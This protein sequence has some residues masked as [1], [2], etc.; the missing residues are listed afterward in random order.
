MFFS[1][2]TGGDNV[3]LIQIETKR[4]SG[5]ANVQDVDSEFLELAKSSGACILDH[6]VITLDKLDVAYLIS[7]GKRNQIKDTIANLQAELVIVSFQLT[8]TQ[9]RN[10]ERLWQCRVIDR[11]GLI[12]DIFAQRA[13]TF[14]GKLQ[15]ELAQLEHL[16]TRLVRGWTHLE[17]QKGGIGLRGPGE[18]QLETDKRL[19]QVRINSL[20][21]R[22][23]KVKK[24]RQNN[25]NRRQKQSIP[26]VA[27][28]GYTNAG[29]S[30]LFNSL[31]QAEVYAADQLFATL[32]TTMR[33]LDLGSGLEV[34]LADT[35]GFIKDLPH[36]LVE[37]FS[38]TLEEAAQADV[39]LHLID[40]SD[41]NRS[42]NILAVEA[43]LQELGIKDI[44]IIK[45]FN[46]IDLL[47][48]ALD[49]EDLQTQ[50]LQNQDKATISAWT[51]AKDGLGLEELKQK[52]R[53]V[54]QLQVC[55]GDL[56][57][58]YAGLGGILRAKLYS[59]DAVEQEFLQD[60]K[61]VL[62]ISL[63]L[64]D[65]K[66]LLIDLNVDLKELNWLAEAKIV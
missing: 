19:I 26:I 65:F 15:V 23:N 31:T 36:Q 54:L 57:L 4:H 10:L 59:L 58:D 41:W 13:R 60:G 42:E 8:S 9:E 17:R 1:R 49:L 18:T 39:I 21:K 32:D 63:A 38:A 37:A 11:V 55:K 61:P 43:V 25:R 56:L 7:S 50:E 20:K 64:N 40:A 33:K 24:Q 16:R 6:Q 12:L 52:I 30:T 45:V 34:V 29:K 27:L 46:K 5:F 35:V 62:K 47:E 3:V 28:V 66:K 48:S 53:E 44:P 51:S 14:E 22:L 2:H